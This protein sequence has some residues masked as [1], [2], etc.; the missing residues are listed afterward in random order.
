MIHTLVLLAQIAATP[1]PGATVAEPPPRLGEGMPNGTRLT[2][3][4]RART[5]AAK[6]AEGAL[7]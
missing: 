2:L 5:L 1:T 7:S 6:P 4:R 3:C